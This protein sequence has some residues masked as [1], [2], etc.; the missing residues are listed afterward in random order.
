VITISS[1]YRLSQ[2]IRKSDGTLYLT[3]R[4][5]LSF[6]NVEGVI[7][8]K[9][10]EGDTLENLAERYYQGLVSASSYWWAIADFQPDPIADN[11]VG[12]T[13]GSFVMI[14]P[15]NLIQD[16]LLGVSDDFGDA[17]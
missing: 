17:V 7:T 8:H 12:L 11:T 10:I 2:V 1:R 14:P 6:A 16:V 15:S 3:E 13:P 9:V 5:T 4:S